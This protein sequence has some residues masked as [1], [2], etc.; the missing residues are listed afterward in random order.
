MVSESTIE[1]DNDFK[2]ELTEKLREE[3]PYDQIWQRLE[4]PDMPDVWDRPEG[5][6]MIRGGLLKIHSVETIQK[7]SLKPH[8]GGL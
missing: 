6:F 2:A 1:L 8:I 3:S 7:I 4:D 5:K